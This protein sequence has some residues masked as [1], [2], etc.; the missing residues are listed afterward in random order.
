M[1]E[2][3]QILH[4]ASAQLRIRTYQPFRGNFRIKGFLSSG[5]REE[6]LDSQ[7]KERLFYATKLLEMRVAEVLQHFRNHYTLEGKAKSFPD[8]GL[9][10]VFLQRHLFLS[11]R[12]VE[13]QAGCFGIVS[14]N[15]KGG[16]GIAVGRLMPVGMKSLRV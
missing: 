4:H 10:Q 8:K 16:T 5:S 15:S 11:Y 12:I 14:S 1:R 6:E 9:A 3:A 2:A 13:G 7:T